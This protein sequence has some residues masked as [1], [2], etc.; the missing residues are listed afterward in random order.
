MTDRLINLTG[1]SVTI[2]DCKGN[3][4]TIPPEGQRL[5]VDSRQKEIGSVSQ[6]PVQVP[7]IIINRQKPQAPP[8]SSAWSPRWPTPS[9]PTSSSQAKRSGT[10]MGVSSVVKTSAWLF[11]IEKDRDRYVY[12]NNLDRFWFRIRHRFPGDYPGVSL[13]LSKKEMKRRYY[14]FQECPQLWQ[15]AIFLDVVVTLIFLGLNIS[16]I[17]F[18]TVRKNQSIGSINQPTVIQ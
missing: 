16:Q 18:G 13:L 6:F 8:T 7:I 3:K 1:H 11:E 9:A 10:S 2:Y 15:T 14:A 17:N 4:L 12:T 5:A